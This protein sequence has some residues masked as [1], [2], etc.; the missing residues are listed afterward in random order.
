[1]VD[2]LPIVDDLTFRLA[3]L[4]DAA[5]VAALHADS[6]RRHYRGAYADDFLDGDVVT[7]RLQVWSERLAADN[8]GTRTHL[9]ESADRLVGFVHTVLDADPTWGALIDNLHVSTDQHRRGIGARLMARAAQFVVDERP[10]SSM[11]LWVLEQNTRGQQFYAA[12]GGRHVETAEVPP[13]GG[14]PGRLNGSPRGL[15]IVWPNPAEILDQDGTFVSRATATT[16]KG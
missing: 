4:D 5:A 1:M 2:R 12:L 9:A 10:G 16:G 13:P 11:Y 7:D 3:T 14:V 8:A 6:W 15:R